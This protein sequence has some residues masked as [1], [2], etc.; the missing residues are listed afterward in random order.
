MGQFNTGSVGNELLDRNACVVCHK[1]GMTSLALESDRMSYDYTCK[2]CNPSVIISISD[3]VLM[4]DFLEQLRDNQEARE[5]LKAEI[6]AYAGKEFRLG[7]GVLEY[8]L[9][10]VSNKPITYSDW[11]NG[12]I[13]GHI[14]AYGDTSPEDLE[15]IAVEQKQIFENHVDGKVS[16]LKRNFMLRKEK[17][18][19]A[20]MMIEAEI[21]AIKNVILKGKHILDFKPIQ[22]DVITI[23]AYSF[24][25]YIL[26]S[27][28]DMYE[29]AVGGSL[30][31]SIIPSEKQ[32]IGIAA[33]DAKVHCMV[34][35]IAFAE[36]LDFL[37]GQQSKGAEN[38]GRY[39]NADI[40]EI[41]NK[42]DDLKVAFAKKF[43]ESNQENHENFLV[44][45]AGQEVIFNEFD[46]MKT[47]LP[48]LTKRTW[49]QVVKGK[50][51]DMVTR[52]VLSK[53]A[54]KWAW[55]QLTSID[56]ALDPGNLLQ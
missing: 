45:Q 20:K 33:L 13:A 5:N 55:E 3:H 1:S 34:E 12:K 42:I 9:G 24:K 50:L 51:W 10:L 56:V 19:N 25:W 16:M 4:S 18:V 49:Q 30:D 7:F 6:A 8:F 41:Q 44:L 27:I 23:G 54:A 38:N 17:S 15:R 37:E 48:S 22:N 40:E 53:E 39:N 28:R 11:K 47:I 31:F 36:F 32:V 46:E 2:V 26:S 21:E 35:A 14:R 52:Q 43:E 29:L